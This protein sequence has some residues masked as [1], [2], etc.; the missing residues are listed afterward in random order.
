MLIPY[1]HKQGIKTK[2]ENKIYSSLK[3]E[4]LGEREI[5]ISHTWPMLSHVYPDMTL[6]KFRKFF[7]SVENPIKSIK[8]AENPCLTKEQEEFVDYVKNSSNDL[9]SMR[10]ILIGQGGS[11]KSFVIDVIKSFFDSKN[12]KYL[13]LAPTGIAAF[14]SKGITIHSAF[15]IP[16]KT[17]YEQEYTRLPHPDVENRLRKV[18]VILIDEISFLSAKIFALI[19]KRLRDIKKVDSEFANCGVVLIGDIYQ[20]ECPISHMVWYSPD[21]VKHLNDWLLDEGLHLYRQFKDIKFFDECVRQKNDN[22]FQGFLHRFRYKK[23]TSDDIERLR[24]RRQSQ[25]DEAEVDLFKDAIRLFATNKKVDNYN[26]NKI[27]TL[28]KPVF[29]CVL[30]EDDEDFRRDKIPRKLYIAPGLPV[31]LRR[32]ICIPLGLVNGS[33]GVITQVLTIDSI[34]SVVT[35]K[36]GNY[37]GPSLPDGSIPIVRTFGMTIKDGR[38]VRVPAFPLQN[39]YAMT[40]HKSQSQT[41]DKVAIELDDYEMSFGLSYTGLSRVKRFS[42]LLILDS[43]YKKDRF[44]SRRFFSGLDL[45]LQEEQRLRALAS[46]WTSK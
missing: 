8:C 23:L 25:L 30:E 44:S 19:A 41:L 32:N 35:V 36:F 4:E 7:C 11:G 10:A 37:K 14:H 17:R 13:S 33:I 34:P 29:A 42:D 18:Q 1:I 16:S 28:N 12:I 3:M 26:K 2:G 5:D 40:I 9:K 38:S 39:G 27:L 6:T 22:E 31:L 21:K 45:R 46:Q 15:G 24:S 20:I 43:D